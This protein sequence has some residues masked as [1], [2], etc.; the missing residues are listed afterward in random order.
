MKGTGRRRTIVELLDFLPI[1][2]LY[3][4]FTTT[5]SEIRKWKFT[6]IM[7]PAAAPNFS[8]VG[9]GTGARRDSGLETG[10]KDRQ[11]FPDQREGLFF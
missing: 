7:C 2:P 9:G 11:P 10:S 3:F 8:A 6:A 1:Q 5:N 4:G